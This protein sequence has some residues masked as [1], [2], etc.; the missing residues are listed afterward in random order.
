MS[1]DLQRI[2]FVETVL[3]PGKIVGE[4]YRVDRLIAEG[5]MA[6]YGLALNQRTGKRVALKVILRSFAA[7]G[8]AAELFHREALAASKVIHPNVVNIF[9][10]H[11]P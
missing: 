8:E 3:Q 7:I 5:G 11:R 1:G 10:R 6:R 2:G 4:K 9:G